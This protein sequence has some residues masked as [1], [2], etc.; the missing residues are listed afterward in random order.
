MYR[1][2]MG[3]LLTVTNMLNATTSDN[4]ERLISSNYDYDI[5]PAALDAIFYFSQEDE[6]LVK[7]CE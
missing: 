1:L 7:L 3:L 4:T 6:I 2:M 5:E